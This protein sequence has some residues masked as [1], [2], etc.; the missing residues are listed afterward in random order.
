MNAW[1]E[2]VLGI[3]A[4]RHWSGRAAAGAMEQRPA[5]DSPQFAVEPDARA[6]FRSTASGPTTTCRQSARSAPASQRSPGMPQQQDLLTAHFEKLGGKVRWQ[7]FRVRHPLDGAPVPMA[8]LIV[9]WHP[10]RKERILLCCPLRHAAVSR[11]RTGATPRGSSS[12]RTTVPAAR[13]S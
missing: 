10:E 9:E 7:E 2:L 12:V 11:S 6:R 1:P 3:V 8:N 4:C 5:C 13:R